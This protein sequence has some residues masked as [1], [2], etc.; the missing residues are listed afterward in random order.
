MIDRLSDWQHGTVRYGAVRYGTVRY[1][2][3]RYRT[4]RYSTVLYGTVRYGTQRYGTVRYVT[5]AT[6]RYGAVR[7]VQYALDMLCDC[8]TDAIRVRCWDNCFLR[9]LSISF[10]R[11]CD[12]G[13]F[14]E[15]ILFLLFDHPSLSQKC[16][17]LYP[18]L[19]TGLLV[20]F[21]RE[22]QSS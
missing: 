4:V 16:N 2:T 1:G 15:Q 21:K 5:D 20:F 17:R 9:S 6:V 8:V 7:H 10:T 11:L 14:N 18:S 19:K 13:S 3:E 12:F 22:K